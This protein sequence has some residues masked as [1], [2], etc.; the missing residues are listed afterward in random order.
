MI[1][2]LPP[3]SHLRCDFISLSF[4]EQPRHTP[5]PQMSSD[6]SVTHGRALGLPRLRQQI[7]IGSFTGPCARGASS[8]GNALSPCLVSRG[9]QS[10][11]VWLRPHRDQLADDSRRHQGLL[12]P[13]LLHSTG[14]KILRN[15][16]SCVP[17]QM[18]RRGPLLLFGR[19]AQ[20]Q[21]RLDSRVWVDGCHAYFSSTSP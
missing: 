8:K 1:S 17:Q 11:W 3:S 5:A 10:A 7:T 9:K 20:R 2:Q 12:W 13:P 15:L 18:A 16:T 19:E 4:L 21:P 6:L 14:M